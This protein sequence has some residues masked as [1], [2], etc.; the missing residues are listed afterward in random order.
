MFCTNEAYGME[1]GAPLLRMDLG[2]GVVHDRDI[3]A[4]INVRNAVSSTGSA[5][6]A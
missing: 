4:A 5:C 6:G 1:Y 3:N 2:C